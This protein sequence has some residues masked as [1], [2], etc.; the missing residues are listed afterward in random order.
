MNTAIQFNGQHIHT[1]THP[2]LQ[3]YNSVKI[4]TMAH[5]YK[6]AVVDLQFCQNTVF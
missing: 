3:V 5:N 1:Y 6:V 2:H 4:T